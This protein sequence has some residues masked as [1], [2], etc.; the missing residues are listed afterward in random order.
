M[1]K[2]SRFEKFGL[3][4]AIL[5]ACT[6]FYVKRVYEPQEA[7]L[8]KTVQE[9]NKVIGQ[10]NS[11]KEVPP[12][13]TVKRAL[14]A[15]R[16][17]LDALNQQMKDNRMRTGSEREVTRL[18]S[19]INQLMVDHGLQVNAL[20]PDGQVKDDLLEWNLFKIDMA[21]SFYGFLTFM[22]ELKALNDAV[23]VEHLQMEKFGDRH[24]H[25][26]LNLLI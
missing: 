9:L 22:R 7:R 16:E 5:I 4:A 26:T 24:L 6:F 10:I 14:E 18:L 19:D 12:P 17:E 25:I 8:K 21:G 2:L 13:T 15:D 20:V 1:R 11:L 23:K 3:V